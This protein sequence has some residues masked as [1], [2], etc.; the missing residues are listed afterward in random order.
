VLHGH[1]SAHRALAG[2]EVLVRLRPR[3]RGPHHALGQGSTG[4]TCWAPRSWTALPR[5]DVIAHEGP[6]RRLHVAAA[7]RQARRARSSSAC[8]RSIGRSCRRRSSPGRRAD[9]SHCMSAA[10]TSPTKC[11]RSG[12]SASA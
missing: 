12:R 5:Q 3:R 2:L 6:Q 10:S 7:D 8:P 11:S 9:A 4:P 1:R